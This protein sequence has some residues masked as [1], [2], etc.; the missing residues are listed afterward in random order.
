MGC[1]MKRVFFKY[2][3]AFFFL[4]VFKAKCFGISDDFKFIIDTIGIPQYNVLGDEIN[5]EIYIAY[6]LFV[7]SN[8]LAMYSRTDLQRFKAVTDKGK[9][10]ENAGMYYGVGK[11][12]EYNILGVSYSGSI[13]NNVYFPVDTVPET[14]PDKWEYV[15][16]PGGYESWQ[17][18]SKY[19]YYEQLEYMKNTRLLFDRIDY[20]NNISD[21]YDLVEYNISSNS[22]GLDKTKLNA[23]ST[24]KTGG[25]VTVKRLNNN[26]QIR[27]AT[28]YTKPMSADA[29]IKSNL[30]VNNS[31]TFNQGEEIEIPITFGSEAVNLSNYAKIEH[32]KKIYSVIYIDG[33]EISKVE[34]SKTD[35][36]E[37]NI[38]INFPKVKFDKPGIYNINIKV[39]SYLYTEFS[40]D[41]LMQDT[42]EKNITIQIDEEKIVPVNNIDVKV[43]EKENDDYI[44][45]DFIKTNCTLNSSI[46]LIQNYKYIAINIKFNDKFNDRD[47][48]KLYINDKEYKLEKIKE[49]SDS[50][51]YRIKLEGCKNT[52]LGWNESRNRTGNYFYINFDDIGK[53]ISEPNCLNVVTVNN[54]NKY[55]NKI[56]FDVIDDYRLNMNYILDNVVNKEALSNKISLNEWLI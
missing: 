1:D 2:I 35:E 29:D 7:Y 42:I 13:I 33:K 12:G 53:R 52:V 20:K 40:I 5:E 39:S 23:V 10:C 50:S 3:V 22:I 44:L 16:V 37:K 47:N 32:I 24:W 4:V 54:L 48:I 27:V 30:R 41:G 21:S 11:R 9:W 49:F 6:N 15:Y 34:G 38:S 8:P 56:Y 14:T 51:I 36:I 18:T 55:E 31:L 28:M 45:R 19:K 46:G 26:G 43:L 17:D 25:I